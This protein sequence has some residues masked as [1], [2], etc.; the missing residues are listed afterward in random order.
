MQPRASNFLAPT[1]SL[2]SPVPSCPHPS[3]PWYFSYASHPWVLS[4]QQ[5]GPKLRAWP[6][7]KVCMNQET[8]RIIWAENSETLSFG[9]MITAWFNKTFSSVW[10]SCSVSYSSQYSSQSLA[11]FCYFECLKCGR[12]I[13][14]LKKTIYVHTSAYGWRLPSWMLKISKRSHTSC[15]RY[16]P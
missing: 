12:N 11:M 10:V 6:R 4:D 8:L 5:C 7:N 9:R 1:Q 15:S 14:I 2:L 16:I 3:L 13:W